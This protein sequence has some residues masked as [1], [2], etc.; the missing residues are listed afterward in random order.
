MNFIWKL[1][2]FYQPKTNP[3]VLFDEKQFYETYF[4]STLA[5]FS[6]VMVNTGLNFL[7]NTPVKD[8]PPV[9]LSYNI[10]N[11]D[12][13]EDSD[14]SSDDEQENNTTD[15]NPYSALLEQAISD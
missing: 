12:Q 2:G 6:L 5:I 15:P 14:D 10:F 7:K 1:L 8:Y 11:N 4:Y 3:P 9:F 13:P